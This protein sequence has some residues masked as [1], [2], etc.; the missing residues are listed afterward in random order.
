MNL[1]KKREVKT[2]TASIKRNI[3]KYCND[4]R[5]LV[6]RHR[7]SESKLKI[8][9]GGGGRNI[10]GTRRAEWS[11]WNVERIDVNPSRN[12]LAALVGGCEYFACT[13]YGEKRDGMSECAAAWRAYSGWNVPRVLRIRKQA[14]IEVL[15]IVCATPTDRWLRY[16][17]IP[18]RL[19]SRYIPAH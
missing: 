5:S 19:A 15:G 1:K 12:R 7:W 2:T 11:R 17:V 8:K 4:T 18:P 14:S 10:R 6:T 9:G 13:T 16:C 3:E